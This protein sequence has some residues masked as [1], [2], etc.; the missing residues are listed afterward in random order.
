MANPFSI[1]QLL[2]GL[3]DLEIREVSIEA[4]RLW[5]RD[6]GAKESQVSIHGPYANELLHL[7]AKRKGMTM[8]M[9]L[10][11]K[12]ANSL[13]GAASVDELSGIVEFW[14]WFVRAG[15]AIPLSSTPNTFTITFLLTRYGKRFLDKNEEDH[16]LL[17][18]ALER[19]R[20]RCPHLPVK[21][22]RGTAQRQSS[23]PRRRLD[24]TSVGLDGR[25]V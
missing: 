15:F 1:A 5:R 24:A 8:D 22:C 21:R 25:R 4:L 6:G 9:P 18:T 7:L 2:D 13:L 17:P 16:P 14:T 3:S 12:L 20:R 23:M 11:T 19:L 10:L